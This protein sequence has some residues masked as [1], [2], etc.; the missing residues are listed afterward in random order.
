LLRRQG[1]PFFLLFQPI[2][3]GLPGALPGFLFRRLERGALS[4]ER[5][6]EQ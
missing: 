4:R 1:L 3:L 6:R 2:P 5:E